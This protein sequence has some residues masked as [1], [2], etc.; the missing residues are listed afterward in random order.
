L[1][2]EYLESLKLLEAKSPGA[3]DRLRMVAEQGYAPAQE[4]LGELYDDPQ[5]LMPADKTEA[6]NWTRKAAEG[7]LA[8][9]MNRLGM[10]YYEGNGVSRDPSLT[11]VWLRRAAKRGEVDSAFNLGALYMKGE[12]VPANPTEAYEWMLIAAKLGDK[13][14]AQTA[15]AL[16]PQL[17]DAQL[18]K[19][20]DEVESFQPLTD[21]SGVSSGSAAA[22]KSEG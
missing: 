13:Q 22:A 3:V 2:A 4:K 12:G 6:F 17:T 16:K 5:G 7:G 18:A 19:V 21:S 8:G 10:M 11:A 1:N 20:H 15:A 9:A 14:G